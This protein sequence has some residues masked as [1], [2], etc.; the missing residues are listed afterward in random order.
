MKFKTMI[1]DLLTAR[2]DLRAIF[3]DEGWQFDVGVISLDAAHI[4]LKAPSGYSG[5]VG[6]NRGVKDGSDTVFRQILDMIHDWKDPCEGLSTHAPVGWFPISTFPTDS[7]RVYPVNV[8]LDLDGHEQ[9]MLT[10]QKP[11]PSWLGW[12]G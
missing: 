8:L 11:D 7:L 1:K 4:T 5:L 12:R 6:T 3:E 10:G 2:D 9:P